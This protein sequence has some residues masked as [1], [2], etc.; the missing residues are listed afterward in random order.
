M[1]KLTSKKK[2]T[3]AT[4]LDYVQDSI[5]RICG[6]YMLPENTFILNDDGLLRLN[7]Q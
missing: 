2:I 4:N 7:S 6:N 3:A 1:K 5:Y